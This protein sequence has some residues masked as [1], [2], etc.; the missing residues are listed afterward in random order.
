L[1]YIDESSD[2][3]MMSLRYDRFSVLHIEAIRELLSKMNQLENR[4]KD[5]ENKV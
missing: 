5:L 2:D 1:V 4:I 3:K